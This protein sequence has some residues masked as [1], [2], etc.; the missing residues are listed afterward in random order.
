MGLWVISLISLVLYRKRHRQKETDRL[1]IRQGEKETERHTGTEKQ[2][3][4]YSGR[5]RLSLMKCIIPTECIHQ[6]NK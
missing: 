5:Q 4:K 3:Y 2:I 6:T 1:R